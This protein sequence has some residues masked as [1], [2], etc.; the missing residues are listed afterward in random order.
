MRLK[1]TASFAQ[2]FVNV[3]LRQFVA[4]CTA[5]MRLPALLFACAAQHAYATDGYF[6][7]S[8][9]GGGRIAFEGDVNDPSDSYATGIALDS[10]GNLLLLGTASTATS[11]YPW[12]GQLQAN[13]QFVPS[14][15]AADGTGRIN[16]CSYYSVQLCNYDYANA[17]AIQPDGRYVVATSHHVFRTTAK[18]LALDT[19]EGNA[20]VVNDAAGSVTATSALAIQSATKVLAAGAGRYSSVVDK[21]LFGVVRLGS[22]LALDPSFGAMKD[23]QQT[24]F[25]GGALVDISAGDAGEVVQSIFVRP[26][27]RIVL[28]GLGYPADGS[29]NYVEAARFSA[30]GLLDTAYGNNGVAKVAW[31]YGSIYDVGAAVMDSAGRIV[32]ATTGI[33][34]AFGVRGMLVTRLDASGSLD[35]S[36][37]DAFAGPGFSFNSNAQCPYLYGNGAAVD[38]AGRILVVGSCMTSSGTTYFAIERLRGDGTL[39]TSFGASGFSLGAYVTGNTVNVGYSI[40]LDAS[41]RPIVAGG[42]GVSALDHAGVARITYDL[43]FT[44]AFEAAPR[45]CSPPDCN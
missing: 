10:G 5:L 13:G 12:L 33:T 26:D 38:S 30:D 17:V 31:S 44:D 41:G 37:G 39:D 11:A 8:W 35:T 1:S 24:T 23:A 43:I 2:R 21:S 34:S 7:T 16:G 28:E 20:F 27:G 15:G 25:A 45:G 40:A 32:V 9:V 14:F 6:D 29:T 3:N 4:R 36:F 22:D 19:L 18:A 42:T